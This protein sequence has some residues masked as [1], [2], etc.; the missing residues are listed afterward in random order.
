MVMWSL[1]AAGNAADDA[2]DDLRRYLDSVLSDPRYGC[3]VNM[4]HMDATMVEELDDAHNTAC[5]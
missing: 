5:A 3:G 1:V 2:A 4:L